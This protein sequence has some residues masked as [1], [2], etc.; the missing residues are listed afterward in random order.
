M[1][2]RKIAKK[3]PEKA[4][5]SRVVQLRG[6][7]AGAPALGP[8]A[9]FA[10]LWKRL[11]EGRYEADLVGGERLE[12]G[13]AP[14]VDLELADRCLAEQEMVLV[15]VLGAEVV[16]FGALRTKER[17]PEEVVIEA[18]RKLV[19]RAGKARLELSADGRVKL[20]GNEVTVDAPREVRLASAHVE[21]P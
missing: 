6:R 14:E 3:S 4:S 18:P 13:V 12:I 2:S 21:I 9:H 20:S 19:L 15:G 17:K 10:K 7:T 11:A 8:G 5:S 16:L 1:T